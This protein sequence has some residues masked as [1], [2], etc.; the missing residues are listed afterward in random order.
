MRLRFPGVPVYMNGRNYFIPSLST[1]QFREHAAVLEQNL[2]PKEGESAPAYIGRISQSILPVILLAIQRNYPDITVE[3]LE[4][5]LDAKT[6]LDSWKA[7]QNA[8]GMTPVTE[9]EDLPTATE[10]T[11]TGPTGA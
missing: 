3:D 6:M 7:T 11:G 2:D 9:G 4:D 1:R 5:W 8:S 10:Q